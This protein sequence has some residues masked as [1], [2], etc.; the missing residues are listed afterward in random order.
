MA[1]HGGNI[2]QAA[3]N[4]AVAYGGGRVPGTAKMHV[5]DTEVGGDQQFRAAGKAQ[6]GAIIA[7]AAHQSA[8]W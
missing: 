3:C 6:N 7:Y 8:S 1:T 4:A 5:F 2:T